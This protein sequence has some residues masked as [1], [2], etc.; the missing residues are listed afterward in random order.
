VFVEKDGPSTPLSSI[1]R[2]M[3]ART[4]LVAVSHVEFLNGY[5]HDMNALGALCSSRGVLLTVDATQSLGVLPV[6]APVW[7]ADIVAAHGYKWL[8]AMHGIAAFYVSEQVQEII[9]PTAPGRS[10]VRGGFESLDYALD[11]HPDA[12][13]FQSG[14]PN[15][16]GM[17]AVGTSLGIV[18]AIGIKAASEQA[19]SVATTVLDG[20]R[21]FGLESTSELNPEHR[22]Q[23]VSFT[24][25]SR[26][27]DQHLVN[28]LKARK[29]AV[30]LRG[31]GIRV[32]AHFWNSR[33][34][35]DRLLDVVESAE[36]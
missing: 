28:H 4:R 10:S 13:R 27:T 25:G 24:T 6:D 2:A 29:I 32:A 31:K 22:S 11:W 15:W 35:A 26:D 1:E 7:Q 19:V 33:E 12:R 34:D 30:G 17:A 36:L 14:G 8:M 3:T 16:I 23:I 9:Q 18:E 21:Q 5:R 20:V